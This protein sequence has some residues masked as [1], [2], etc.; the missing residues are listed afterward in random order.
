[1]TTVADHQLDDLR[2]QLTGPVL[3]GGFGWLTHQFGLSRYDP[4]N[5]FHRNP[6]IR[7]AS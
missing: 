3:G 7:P 1:M 5:V 4:G 6:N 2:R